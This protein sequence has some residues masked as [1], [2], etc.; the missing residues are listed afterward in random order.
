[1]P[2]NL[3][4]GEMQG[5]I[6]SFEIENGTATLTGWSLAGGL[7][8]SSEQ[9]RVDIRRRLHRGDVV[10]ALGADRM[11]ETGNADGRIG[12]RAEMEWRDERL[13]LCQRHHHIVYEWP[14]P[15]QSRANKTATFRKALLPFT[16]ALL[17]S[18]P[19]LMRS[20]SEQ[21]GGS[22]SEELCQRLGLKETRASL[23]GLASEFFAPERTP[24]L[25]G[26]D[27][28][29]II[30]PVYNALGM[31]VEC[32]RRVEAH[33][34]LPWHLILVEDAS[35][36][37]QIR[38]WLREWVKDRASR[39]TLLENE[40]NLGFVASVN[41]GLKIAA[42]RGK[43]VV[44]LNSDAFVPLNWASRLLAPIQAYPDI[45]S[46][47]PMSNDATIF[48]VPYI[49]DRTDLRSGAVDIIDAAAARLS[50][51]AHADAPCGVGFCMALSSEALRNV[52]A[53]DMAFGR[54]YGEEVDWCQ[55]LHKLG[56]RNVGIGNLF[57]EHRGGSSFGSDTKTQAVADAGRIISRRHPGFD[58][59]VQTFIRNDPLFTARL[60]L[61]IAHASAMQDQPLCFYLAHS[62]GGGAENWLLKMIEAA[63]GAGQS[64]VVIRVG[65]NRRFVI[66]LHLGGDVLIGET[67]E[68]STVVGMV[69][70]TERRNIVYSCGVGDAAPIE[71]PA[72]LCSLA[73]SEKA[74]LEMLF[75]DYLPI[76][77]SYN[78]LDSSGTYR[79]IP[80]A[81][82][83]D[84]AH[85][86]RFGEG[87]PATLLDWR[88]AW[89]K[90][91]QRSDS[92]TVFSKSSRDI[93]LTVWPDARHKIKISPHDRPINMPPLEPPEND[94]INRPALGILGSIGDVKGAGFVSKLAWHIHR[95]QLG[96][97]LVVIGE[98]DRSFSLPS[99]VTIT[100]R[101][102]V[103]DVANITRRHRVAAWLMPS[104][105]PETFSFTT[106]EM[107]ATGLPV[108][109]FD[110]GAQGEAVAA[111]PNGVIVDQEP[112][113][114][115]SAFLEPY[116][117]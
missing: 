35:T 95:E 58:A 56:M 5:Y 77:P 22:F 2:L 108:F 30:L 103:A 10:A 84:P 33:T 42:E 26:T 75:H 24:P 53:F 39:V 8:V 93:V 52:P 99:E 73:D 72:L 7:S 43:H 46:V 16:G 92:I 67:D 12:F 66:E 44:L 18:L 38:P 28:I 79:G 23:H 113:A 45:A 29:T 59:E 34:D 32:L 114:V 54:G 94:G 36:D 91:V 106:H 115:V 110:V 1:M 98:F 101:Y 74:T 64:C 97:N 61:A 11:I 41:R 112:E 65:G 80:D 6:D 20:N 19:T 50:S 109:A 107:L 40:K 87:Q 117:Q 21:R 90:A 102:D 9:G 17:K 49:A 116:Q 3:P 78:L 48:T 63:K 4:D 104:I 62:L 83:T 15:K 96:F 81:N 105:C 86:P 37:Q 47:T 70:S 31:L 68:I 111:A 69:G 100:G 60:Y 14:L 55:R 71:L 89:G 76:S 25:T 82:D 57:V 88:R 27:E 85:Q 13:I 51:A